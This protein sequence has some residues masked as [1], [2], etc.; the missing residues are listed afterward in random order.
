MKKIMFS[1]F[2]VYSNEA[3]SEGGC[4]PGQY[5]QRGQGWQACVPGESAHDSPH[6]PSPHWERRWAAIATDGEAAALGTASRALSEGMAMSQALEECRR[7]GGRFCKLQITHD[8]GCVAM[9][10]GGN[11]M[12]F[13]SGPTIPWVEKHALDKCIGAEKK[14][15]I[16]HSFCSPPELVP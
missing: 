4:P 2:L 5:P 14:P 1:L 6:Q 3:W 15:T 8:N 11:M 10:I 13:S 12:C 7:N 9:A 16:Y